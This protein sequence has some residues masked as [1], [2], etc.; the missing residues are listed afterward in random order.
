MNRRGISEGER[1]EGR[2]AGGVD[3]REVLGGDKR[4]ERDRET[5][6]GICSARGQEGARKGGKRKGERQVRRQGAVGGDSERER[7]GVSIRE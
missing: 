2:E 5:N 3:M 1:K 6:V 7:K 4:E